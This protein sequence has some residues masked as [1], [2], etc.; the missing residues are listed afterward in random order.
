MCLVFLYR[1]LVPQNLALA[2]FQQVCFITQI[3]NPWWRQC[4]I[5]KC[6]VEYE[7]EADNQ[8][9]SL[10]TINIFLIVFLDI[11]LCGLHSQRWSVIHDLAIRLMFSLIFSHC[12][13][14]AQKCIQWVNMYMVSI[15]WAWSSGP[16][17]LDWPSG[18]RGRKR[19]TLSFTLPHTFA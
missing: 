8:K 5:Q 18:R 7:T 3:Y 9:S 4:N 12:F 10:E 17:F 14:R 19:E 11:L 6:R 13:R 1:N 2:N 15:L 16:L